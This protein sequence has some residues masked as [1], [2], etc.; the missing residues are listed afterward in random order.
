MI[1]FKP[2]SPK[3]HNIIR[4]LIDEKLPVWSYDMTKIS[5]IVNINPAFIFNIMLPYGFKND[6]LKTQNLDSVIYYPF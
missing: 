5:D 6:R 2:I 1:I 4:H 3:P